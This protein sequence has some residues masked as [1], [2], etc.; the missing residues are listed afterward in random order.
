MCQVT[1]LSDSFF[2][3][4]FINKRRILPKKFSNTEQ[5]K[6]ADAKD[7]SKTYFIWNICKL[8]PGGLDNHFTYPNGRNI[9]NK[10]KPL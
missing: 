1:K 2:K 5:L 9:R 4:K 6:K 3:H 8:S 7:P 10:K